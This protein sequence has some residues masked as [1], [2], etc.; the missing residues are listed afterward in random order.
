VSHW[1]VHHSAI[2]DTILHS[3][4]CDIHE[5]L[6]WIMSHALQCSLKV[7]LDYDVK[8]FVRLQCSLRVML[9]YN[10]CQGIMVDFLLIVTSRVMLDFK[11]CQ[12]LC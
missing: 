9:D 1:D 7:M 4:H 5:G 6:C 3:T 8:G 11:I 10:I 12:G 2:F